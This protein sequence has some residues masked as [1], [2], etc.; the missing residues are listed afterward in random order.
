MGKAEQARVEQHVC[1]NETVPWTEQP[2]ASPQADKAYCM[3][4]YLVTGRPGFIGSN[5]VAALIARGEAVRVLDNFSTGRGDS[6][7]PR[8][9][10]V[11]LI[12]GD[13]RDAS[14][15]GQALDGV[16]FVPHRAVLPSVQRSIDAPRENHEV[17][18]TSTLNVLV[19]ARD[20]GGRRM[21]YASS[22][23]ILSLIHI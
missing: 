10:C 6:I 11:D 19:A 12:E 8:L 3:S 23:S 5:I 15:A 4:S 18:A 2:Y 16:E 22:P 14:I 21:V 13:L 7:A 20:A 17:N 9:G 1:V